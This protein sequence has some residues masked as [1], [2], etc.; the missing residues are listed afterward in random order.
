MDSIKPSREILKIC[1]KLNRKC[2]FS[3]FEGM[4][5]IWVQQLS[6]LLGFIFQDLSGD[7]GAQGMIYTFMGK[8]ETPG[9][10]DHGTE[11]VPKK[12]RENNI[13]ARYASFLGSLG[14]GIT[15]M[16]VRNVNIHTPCPWTYDFCMRDSVPSVLL[17]CPRV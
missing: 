4:Y 15:P 17:L 16:S 12:A 5:H 10:R 2:V 9:R 13:F 1:I 6:L 11:W 3:L 8:L 7:G 14:V